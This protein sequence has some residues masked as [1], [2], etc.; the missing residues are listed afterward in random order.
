M[1]R[2]KLLLP[3]LLLAIVYTTSLAQENDKK[4][5][6][7][8]AIASMRY[9]DAYVKITYSRPEKRGRE[10]FGKLVPYG[11]VWRTG[12]NEATE[13]T[14]TKNIQINGF[15]LKAGTYSIFTIPEKEK[16]TIIINADLGLWGAYNYNPKLDLMRFEV[17]VQPLTGEIYEQFTMQLDPHNELADLAITWDKV[18]VSIPL[19]FIN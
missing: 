12:A 18:N 4:R 16:W 6:S 19:K 3:I 2:K 15:L 8:L 14:V 9:K 13:I 11:Q 10:I 7:P 5:T 1:N 17:P